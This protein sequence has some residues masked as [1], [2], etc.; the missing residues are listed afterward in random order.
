MTAYSRAARTLVLVIL[1]VAV[2]QLGT[3]LVAAETQNLIDSTIVVPNLNYYTITRDIDIEGLDKVLIEGTI[4]VS[5][6]FISLY[7]MDS[8]GYSVFVK[9]GD[10]GVTLYRADNIQSH[11]LAVA[12]AESGRYYI[13]LDNGDFFSSRTVRIK[14]DLS[15]EK[16]SETLMG[17]AVIAII[18]LVVLVVIVL[19]FRRVK[20]R[21]APK[22]TGLS[23]AMSADAFV[24]KNCTYCGAVMHQM[25]K[26]CPA[27]GQ[28]Q[29]R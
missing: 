6:G 22:G 28:E 3:H 19:V 23:G 15:F 10:P 4:E 21:S 27:C 16:P 11:S 20:R 26:T 18:A 17:Y 25:A 2:A 13:V 29:R 7:V 24:P 1:I 8:S 12:I 5:D 14:L 9:N